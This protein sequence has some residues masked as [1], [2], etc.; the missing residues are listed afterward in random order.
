M[1]RS[2]ELFPIPL[3]SPSPACSTASRSRRCQARAQLHRNLFELTTDT[4]SALN[5]LASSS[6]HK[7]IHSSIYRKCSRFLHSRRH[8]VPQPRDE[9]FVH[10]PHYSQSSDGYITKQQAAWIHSAA[11]V[12][13]PAQPPSTHLLDVLPPDLAQ[14]YSAPNSSLLKDDADVPA[15]LPRAAMLISRTEYISLLNRL[16]ALRMVEFRSS[17]RAVN[18]LFAVPKDDG[19]LRL[20][21]DFRPANAFFLEPEHTPL[22]TPDL[23]ASLHGAAKGRL[24]VAKS[25]LADYYHSLVVP[26]WLREFFGLPAVPAELVG[27]TD[28]FEVGD[29]IF[30]VFRT[31][32][33]GFSH[34]LRLAQKAHEHLVYSR[35]EMDPAD[36][37]AKCNDGKLDRTR[38]AIYVDDISWIGPDRADVMRQQQQYADIFNDGGLFIKWSKWRK[39]TQEPTE[40]IGMELDPSN[41]TIGL[42]A[43]KLDRLIRDTQAL[44]RADTVLKA[45]FRWLVGKWTWAVLA[46]RSAL[47]ALNSIYRFLDLAPSRASIWPS[48]RSELRVL[49]GLAPLLTV[50]LS[51]DWFPLV[52]ASDASDTGLGVAVSQPCNPVAIADAVAE[53]A[54]SAHSAITSLRWSVAASAR[55][56]RREHIVALEARAA[57]CAVRY[58]ISRPSS[59]GSRVVLLVDNQSVAGALCKGRSSSHLLLR[60]LRAVTAASLAADLHLVTLWVPSALNP[61]DEPSRR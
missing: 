55:W 48:V 23:L 28:R 35:T 58:A 42:S 60:R 22:P 29:L 12:S 61:A 16:K 39:P 21:A 26:P 50:D 53:S 41:A 40:V 59:L 7:R 33:M 4:I 1:A 37:I 36:A 45:R 13:L 52:L 31:L 11:A 25:D 43:P 14:Q 57:S 18:G 32:P 6:A 20:I 5:T 54:E 8:P 51:A 19:R 34:S 47:S 49:I 15:R 44:L 27:E 10:K 9:P 17:V 46:R 30:P 24:W 2:G 3:P 56:R 38:H